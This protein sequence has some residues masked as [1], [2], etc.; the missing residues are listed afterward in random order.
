MTF[1]STSII[2]SVFLGI[3][4]KQLTPNKKNIVLIP[5]QI[6]LMVFF[7]LLKFIRFDAAG[8]FVIIGLVGLCLGGA[9][10]T[11]VGLVT[12]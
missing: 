2:G 4:L 9:Y 11:M 6:L 10:N 12:M 3:A 5:I 1:D 8:Y 7:T